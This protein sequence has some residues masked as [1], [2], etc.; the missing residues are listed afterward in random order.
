MAAGEFGGDGCGFLQVVDG[1]AD[2][3]AHGVGGG[4]VDEVAGS[5]FGGAVAGVEVAGRVDGVP[6]VA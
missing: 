2:L 3:A 6:G 5:S 4:E 1:F